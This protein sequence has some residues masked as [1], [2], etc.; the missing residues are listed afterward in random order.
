MTVTEAQYP[1]RYQDAH[2]S[3][4]TTITNDGA[5]LRMVV[6]GVAWVGRD[7]DQLEPEDGTPPARLATFT[8]A[9]GALCDCALTFE[10]PAVVVGPGGASPATIAVALTLGRPR[11]S[12]GID[13][14][15]VRCALT[16]AGGRVEGTGAS[17]WFEDE[18]L[19]LQRQLPPDVY[20]R[21]CI[22][23][24]YSDYSPG[25]HGLFG[26]LLCFRNVKAAYAQVHSKATFW[27]VLPLAERAVQETD[28]CE[29]F[30]RRVP[31]TGYRG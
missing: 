28:H 3:E 11:P 24:Q 9:H 10:M 15:V 1:A 19:E 8:L 20:L 23:C 25:G 6:R 14:E 21:S 13:A 17:G 16:W 2:G 29:Q 5:C 18:L 12:G 26:D 31:G 30:A 7:F 4:P 27:P 22:N